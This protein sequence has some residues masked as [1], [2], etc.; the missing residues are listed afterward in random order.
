MATRALSRIPGTKSRTTRQSTRRGDATAGVAVATFVA[1]R[2]ASANGVL[3]S[4]VTRIGCWR[5]KW[6][7][8]GSLLWASAAGWCHVELEQVSPTS[9]RGPLALQGFRSPPRATSSASAPRSPTCRSAAAA[10]FARSPIRGKRRGLPSSRWSRSSRRQRPS[11]SGSSCT[12]SKPSGAQSGFSTTGRL[13]CTHTIT[14]TPDE[15]Y[16]LVTV[17]ALVHI[18][19]KRTQ[20][21]NTRNAAL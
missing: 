13:A 5:E 16:P 9:G 3:R 17:H 2:T 20:T 6:R 1:S 12:S 18:G 15:A 14:R 8:N 7:Q 19:R 10:P 4:T 21:R 11:P